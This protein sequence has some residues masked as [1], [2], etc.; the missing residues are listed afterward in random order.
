MSKWN[1]WKLIHK[2]TGLSFKQYIKS[3]KVTDNNGLEHDWSRDK[4]FPVMLDSGIPAVYIDQAYYPSLYFLRNTDWKIEMK[5][6]EESE[7]IEP[8][9]YK[10]GPSPYDASV[11]RLPRNI[12]Y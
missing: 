4:C 1:R 5:R 10:R 11:K 7:S 8:N 6:N 2:E 9:T 12:I 3:H